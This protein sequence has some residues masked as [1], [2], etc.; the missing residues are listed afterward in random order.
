MDLSFIQSIGQMWAIP[1]GVGVLFFI[2]GK[3]INGFDATDVEIILMT[4]SKRFS[5]FILKIITISSPPAI[6]VS[7]ILLMDGSVKV[8]KTWEIWVL[9]GLPFFLYFF[10]FLIANALMKILTAIFR[11]RGKFYVSFPE[12]NETWYII[13]RPNRKEILLKD[14]NNGYLY[15][16]IKK[17]KELVIYREQIY[18]SGKLKRTYDFLARHTVIKLATLTILSVICYVGGLFSVENASL[19]ISLLSVGAI[20]FLCLICSAIVLSNSLETKKSEAKR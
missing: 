5:L 17:I 14:K 12:K 18:L 1:S 19:A 20:S 11:R 2:L 13:R 7:F 10:V 4:N 15:Y 3:L 8:E 9:L 6:I 16:D